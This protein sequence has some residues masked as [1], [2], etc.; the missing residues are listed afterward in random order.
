MTPEVAVDRL[1]QIL[2]ARAQLNEDD[3]YDALTAA[4]VPGPVA[5]RAYKFTQ[6]AWG[7][8][9][10][11]GLGIHFDPEHLCFDRNG[12]VIESG[13]LA[14]QPYFVAA[15]A[16]A[17]KQPPPA[18]LP[19]FALMS[20]DVTVVNNALNAGS[21]PEDLVTGPAALFME[22]P[23]SEGIAKARQLLRQRAS[24]AAGKP[25]GPGRGDSGASRKA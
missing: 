9:L 7:R 18:S 21:K 22:A 3:I 1:V 6:I 16:A 14:E 5:D 2:E 19:R 23:T 20:A 4:G 17:R 13:Q 11:D 10:L 15:L 12:A 25:S 24:A 8:L